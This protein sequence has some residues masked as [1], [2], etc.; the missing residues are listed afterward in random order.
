MSKTAWMA[1]DMFHIHAPKSKNISVRETF[2]RSSGSDAAPLFFWYEDRCCYCKH[3]YKKTT[4][5]EDVKDARRHNKV[6]RYM[7]RSWTVMN[8]SHCWCVHC[9]PHKGENS[10]QGWSLLVS[11][12]APADV[13]QYTGSALCSSITSPT[14]PLS[15]L[16][17]QLHHKWR[18]ENIWQEI[19]L[20]G[21]T[22]NLLEISHRCLWRMKMTF[23]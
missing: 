6:F 8:Y 9:S 2:F 21:C 16:T 20:R 17:G 7:L 14:A 1:L 22:H 15:G 18:E 4:T 11:E 23:T 3:I 5:C 13:Q 12:A 19:R 10:L